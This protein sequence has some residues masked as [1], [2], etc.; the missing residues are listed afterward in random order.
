MIEHELQ[1][2]LIERQETLSLAES[3]TGGG[4]S[5]RLVKVPDCS[6]YFLGGLVSYSGA[7]KEKLLKVKHE[8]IQKWGE[9]SEQTAQEMAQGALTAFGSTHA[10]AVTGIA[11]P[12]GGSPEKPIGTVF[13]A[14]ASREGLLSKK[15]YLFSGAREEIISKTIEEAL[16]YLLNSLKMI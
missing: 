10:L 3:C 16:L 8:T 2:L 9:V 14:I 12:S 6:H 15:H 11:G 4:I 7:A 1:K 13:V 5:A